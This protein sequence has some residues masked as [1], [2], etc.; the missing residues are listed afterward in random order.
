[1]LLSRSDGAR[2]HD[3]VVQDRLVDR[4]GV[5]EVVDRATY[6]SVRL[7][8]HLA[9]LFD[10]DHAPPPFAKRR[11]SFPCGVADC[12]YAFV[13]AVPLRDR[14]HA[15]QQARRQ[16]P[17]GATRYFVDLQL[18]D[19]CVMS[20]EGL[21]QIDE[22]RVRAAEPIAT[23]TLRLLREAGADVLFIRGSHSGRV[24]VVFTQAIGRRV[25]VVAEGAAT[26]GDDGT[27]IPDLPVRRTAGGR[28]RTCLIGVGVGRPRV[29][30][31]AWE[32]AIALVC[33]LLAPP[34]AELAGATL[35]VPVWAEVLLGGTAAGMAAVATWH[36]TQVG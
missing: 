13:L 34:L 4:T 27:W 9:P 32:L 16:M 31:M 35:T 10:D 25:L 7:A 15:E 12:A 22:E 8:L 23:A 29:G 21:A 19:A 11:D 28:S 14:E 20:C 1:M 3:C 17:P 24:A 2:R 30:R 33:F 18:A 36:G 26:V 6:A 5:Q